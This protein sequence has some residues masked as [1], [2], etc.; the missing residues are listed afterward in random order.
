MKRTKVYRRDIP[1]I[2][3]GPLTRKYHIDSAQWENTLS[4]LEQRRFKA[5]KLPKAGNRYETRNYYEYGLGAIGEVGGDTSGFIEDVDDWENSTSPQQKSLDLQRLVTRLSHA[6]NPKEKEQDGDGNGDGKGNQKQEGDQQGSSGR[7]QAPREEEEEDEEE[8]DYSGGGE[9]KYGNVD[10]ASLFYAVRY[11]ISKLAE[12]DDFT[13]TVPFG[14]AKWDAKRVLSAYWDPIL[15]EEAKRNYARQVEDIYL[16]LDVSGSVEDLAD[17]IA[18]IAAGAAGIV[19]LYQGQE[20][21]PT[22]KVL[23]SVPLRTPRDPFPEWHSPESVGQRKFSN[24]DQETWR[25]AFYNE[26]RP[27][28]PEWA[29]EMGAFE[30]ELAWFLHVEKPPKNSR[31]LFWGDTQVARFGCPRLMASLL[32]PYR[33]AWL[34]SEPYRENWAESQAIHHSQNDLIYY[35]SRFTSP[36]WPKLE[37]V[38]I[39]VIENVQTAEHVRGMLQTLQMLR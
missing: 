28:Y 38:G 17:N 29:W 9:N 19:H 35:P 20:A 7:G 22:E 3:Q 36:E 39:P 34:L 1:R 25:E 30:M 14:S 26:Q 18:A 31:I 11:L 10:D 33:A 24:H 23:R 2:P 32:R 27:L 21:R 8:P 6:F 13:E 37:A 5:S 15:L 12:H 16:I 4:W